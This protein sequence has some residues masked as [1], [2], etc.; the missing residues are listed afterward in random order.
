[1]SPCQI[2]FRLTALT[3]QYRTKQYVAIKIIVAEGAE[4]Y[5]EISNLNLL[6]S[7]KATQDGSA[8]V[9]SLVDHFTICGPNGTHACIVLELLG[10]SV[11]VYSDHCMRSGR[12]PPHAVKRIARDTLLGLQYIH[13]K[14][15]GH[16]GTYT[17]DVSRTLPDLKI[18]LH[19]GNIFIVARPKHVLDDKKSHYNIK[20]ST[21]APVRRTDGQ[22]LEANMPKYL[23][24][25]SVDLMNVPPEEL[26]AKI[27]D[28]GESFQD[29]ELLSED[30]S[31][32]RQLRTARVVRAPEII[33]GDTNVDHRADMWSMGCVVSQKLFERHQC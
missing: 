26:S 32:K 19:T 11:S 16:G 21:R 12:L 17:H 2:P 6:S 9:V 7:S 20:D 29:A 14:G 28:L 31:N 5:R 33:F 10:P 18:D 4:P 22:S 1:M 3:H 8:Q 23:Y 15:I 27:G 24:K 25:A 30:S 13:S